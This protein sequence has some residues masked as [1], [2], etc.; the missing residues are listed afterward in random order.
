M[1]Q[2]VG[3]LQ[4]L[5]RG[6]RLQANHKYLGYLTK[7]G[8]PNV[9]PLIFSWLVLGCILVLVLLIV[10]MT[11]IP[12]LPIEP[13]WTLNNWLDV[14]RPYVLT[15]V[16]P[17]TLVV[18]IGTVLIATF[19]ATPMAWLLHRTSLPYRNLFT[20]LIAS[21]VVIPGFVKA[22]GWIMLINPRFGLFNRVVAE[23]LGLQSVPL[24]MNNPLG[25]AWVMG[26]MLAP[27]MF[28]L[29]SGSVQ[30]LDPALEEAAEMSGAKKWRTIR[31]VSF[32]L[33]WPAISA[34]AIYIFMTAI[35][36]FEVPAMLGAAGGQ[37]PVLATEFFYAV[38]PTTP[39]SIDLNYGA[40]GVYGVLIA[41]PS[42]V[43]LYF[44]YRV[45]S[46]SRQFE[47]ITGRGYRPRLIDLGRFKYAG[48]AFVLTYLAL[49]AVLP[50]LILVWVSLAPFLQM[51]SMEALSKLSL[52]NYRSLLPTIGGMRVIY[53]T[54]I[55]VLGVSLFVLFFSFMVS[56]VVV[57][58]RVRGRQFMD[59]IA[60]LPHAIPG[61]GFAFALFILA[62]LLTRWIPWLALSGTLTIIVMAHV[63]NRLAYG[64]R[65]T[66]A[67]LLQIHQELEESAK[68]CGARNFATWFWV[69]VPLIRPSLVYAGLWT[70]LLS[71]REVTMALFLTGP[72]NTVLSVA[73]WSLWR[74]GDLTTA[75]ATAVV[76]VAIM[77]VL[78]LI[79]LWLIGGR[80]LETRGPKV[81]SNLGG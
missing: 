21:V 50:L 9:I 17:N 11:F 3:D 8:S 44:Y 69:I 60:M 37:A 51:P 28:F 59:T 80:M 42:L 62:V 79:T 55:L 10:Y 53:N 34:G 73:T 75:A 74:A 29:I 45:L 24:D 41:A 38:N 48:L 52:D 43:A 54:V 23:S 26:L 76:M 70:A 5:R 64:T 56:W 16:L 25:M 47:V 66:N 68:I 81:G 12:G 49:A 19:F 27:T 1:D 65:I 6:P 58:S 31:Y 46:R 40:A 7:A 61:L 4:G 30:A 36:I 72:K 35:S 18:G 78:L 39:E 71:F 32:P 2:K 13:G 15:K 63:L 33:V 22:M 20:A 14:A 77:V 57:R 67:A